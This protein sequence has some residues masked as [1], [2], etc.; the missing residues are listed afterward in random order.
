MI[1]KVSIEKPNGR[2]ETHISDENGRAI[3]DQIGLLAEL[4]GPEAVWTFTP[5]AD[6]D[7]EPVA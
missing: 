2:L 1:T 5:V 7:A 6:A 3:W 4:V